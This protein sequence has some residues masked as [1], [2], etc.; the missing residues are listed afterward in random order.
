[1]FFTCKFYFK[2]KTCTIEPQTICSIRLLPGHLC[3]LSLWHV[4]KMRTPYPKPGCHFISACA[5]ATV[6][7][8]G[9]LCLIS[10]FLQSVPSSLQ[11][12]SEKTSKRLIFVILKNENDKSAAQAKIKFQV[13]QQVRLDFVVHYQEKG[14]S[15]HY[16]I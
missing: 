9:Y 8:L 1:M 2:T 16:R 13:F 11:T 12:S 14:E 15:T 4:E 10:S 7:S 3:K 6:A 5:S